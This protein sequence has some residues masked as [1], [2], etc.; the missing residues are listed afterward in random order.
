MSSPPETDR[1]YAYFRAIGVGDVKQ[2]DQAMN[3]SGSEF[4]NVGD[5]FQPRDI[6]FTR[7]SS[8]WQLDS[9]HDDKEDLEKHVE[10]LLSKLSSKVEVLRSISSEFQLQIVCVS[11]TYQSFSF[12]L[13]FELQRRAT[14]LGISFWFNFY[15]FGDIHE[16]IVALREELARSST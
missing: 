13:P 15:P 10:A 6:V 8:C 14:N 3:L 16:E 7:K 9:G 2:I 12:E 4:W 5:T 11:F 1:E